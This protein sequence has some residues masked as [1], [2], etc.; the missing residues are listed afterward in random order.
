MLTHVQG[1]RKM[2]NV[3][4]R[5][6]KHYYFLEESGFQNLGGKKCLRQNHN[7]LLACCLD[8]KLNHHYVFIHHRGELAY[9]LRYLELLF[10][11]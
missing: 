7:A 5:H 6:S 9:Y 2:S 11:L 4:E 3:L 10:L 8:K 1:V